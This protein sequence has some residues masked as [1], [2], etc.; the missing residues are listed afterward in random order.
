[1][2]GQRERM[3]D[4]FTRQRKG[5]PIAGINRPIKRPTPAAAP[6]RPSWEGISQGAGRMVDDQAAANRAAARFGKRQAFRVG[7]PTNRKLT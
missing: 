1:M 5:V 3:I 4:T 7:G 2:A 6:G